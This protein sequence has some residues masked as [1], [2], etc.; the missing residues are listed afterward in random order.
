MSHT[1]SRVKSPT[2][3]KIRN[4]RPHANASD[5]KSSDQR[6]LR[7]CGIVIGARVPSARLRPPRRRTASVPRDTCAGTSCA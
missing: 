1:H 3:A 4:L 2:T 7:P 6:W 5:T